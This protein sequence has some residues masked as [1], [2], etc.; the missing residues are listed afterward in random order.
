MKRLI[1]SMAGLLLLASFSLAPVFAGIDQIS[2]LLSVQKELIS[3]EN[4]EPDTTKINYVTELNKL[5]IAGRPE[6]DNAA[7]YYE[8]A[9]ELYVKH[10]EGLKVSTRSWPKEQP[11]QEHAL[12]K[13]WVQDNNRALEQIQLGSKKTYCWF[14]H[15]G[16]T[17]HQP[18]HQNE[19][20]HLRTEKQ[21]AYALQARA[22]LSAEDGNITSATNDILTLYTFGAHVANGPK[23]LIEKLVGITIK[24]FSIKASFNLLDKK[25]VDTNLMKTLE[26]KFKQLVT[27]YSEPFDIRGE[28]IFMQEQVE[29]DPT[30][31]GLKPY[32]KLSLIHI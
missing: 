27:N 32:L 12:L 23:I 26:D 6:S 30:S 15:T 16:Q 9:I 31:R 11:A 8:K 7:P 28:K 1:I 5:G 21:L 10:P 17:L 22:M 19:M 29:T 25:M 13:K 20:P 4:E 3:T 14:K 18:E 24:S 2:D